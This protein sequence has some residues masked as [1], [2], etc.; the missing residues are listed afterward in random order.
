MTTENGLTVPDVCEIL[1]QRGADE[2]VVGAILFYAALDNLEENEV[3]ASDASARGLLYILDAL[4]CD[5][6]LSISCS[7]AGYLCAVWKYPDGRA[8]T[9]GARMRIRWS[10]QPQ[11][12]GER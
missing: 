6:E 3:P 11:T 1:L 10:M 12:L 5:G 2:E 4:V 7:R 8:S 9:S